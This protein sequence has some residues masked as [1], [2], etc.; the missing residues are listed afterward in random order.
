MK[1]SMFSNLKKAL[2]VVALIVLLSTL[3]FAGVTYKDGKVIFTFK[4]QANVVYL[5]G[6][7]NNWSPTAWA[8][9]LVDGVWTYEAELKPGTYQYKFVI[10]GKTWKEDPEAPAY[11]DD[12]FGGKN[13]IFTLTDDGKIVAPE[14]TAQAQTQQGGKKYILNEKR[15][16]TIFVDADGYVIIRYYNKD[17]KQ[18]YIAGSFNNWKADDT[19]L[20]F[21]EDG[22]WEAVLELQPGVY[23]YKFVVDGNWIPDPNAFAYTDDGFGGLNAVIEVASEGGKLVVKAPATAVKEGK[24]EGAKVEEKKPVA[25]VGKVTPGLSIVDGKVVFAVKKEN[26]QEAYLA[27]S[28]NGWNPRAQKMELI[29]GYWVTTLA[30]QPGVHKYKFV[31]VIG[32]NDVWEED[33]LAPAYEPDG[34]GGKNGVFKLVEKDGKLAIE[35]VESQARGLPVKGKYEFTYEFST[36]SSKILVFSGATNK[37]TLTFNP[38][39]DLT[40]TIAYGGANINSALFKLASDKL[41]IGFHYKS[42]WDFPVKGKDTG[43]VFSYDIAKNT[44]LVFG[45]GYENSELPLVAGVTFGGLSVYGAKGY[46]TNDYSAL[47]QY[48][49]EVPFTLLLTGMYSLDNTYYFGFDFGT[50]KLALGAGFD[51]A[52]INFYGSS[53]ISSYDVLLQGELDIS[54]PDLVLEI[55]AKD[56]LY[57]LG[58]NYTL[59]TQ[60]IS[61]LVGIFD[62][63]KELNLKISFNDLSNI[64]TSTTL[65]LSGAINF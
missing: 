39:P 19:P 40:L 18:P 46:F 2:F 58:L 16:N 10:D 57:K 5:A 36:D 23:E 48:L 56:N 32:G 63:E 9:K 59:S 29:D 26:A 14:G 37:L 33:P 49:L 64:L 50:E 43:I 34:F 30:L 52:I 20:Y 53:K 51:G 60:V 44:K 4:A 1:L 27:G 45:L 3:S 55:V 61:F 7:F 22:W 24:Q 31:F 42:A 17:A 21:I 8:M 12:G 6:T 25:T 13:G 35:G 54:T 65:T 41:T 47:A 15:E 38:N 62:K 11:V 28:F